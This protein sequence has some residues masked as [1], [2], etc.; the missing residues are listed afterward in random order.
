MRRWIV[1]VFLFGVIGTQL[2]AVRAAQAQVQA[3]QPSS[4][5]RLELAFTYTASRANFVPGTAFWMQGGGAEVAV[6]AGHGF[7]AVGSI[8]GMHAGP[9]TSGVPLSM[10]VE[11]FGPRYT[12]SPSS[13]K[14]AHGV[15]VFGQGLIGAAQGFSS[16]FPGASGPTSN[17]NSLAFQVG[18]GVDVKLSRYLALRAGELQ[19]LRTELP[20][21]TT[22]V[23]NSL[24]VAAGIVFKIPAR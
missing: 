7:S 19:W 17:A 14:G 20:N 24:L 15:S 10:M 23:Q 6:R 4:A 13:Q 16:T 8:A 21:S 12:L 18:G 5:G 22:N 11:S 3:Q 9:A 2:F 1:Y